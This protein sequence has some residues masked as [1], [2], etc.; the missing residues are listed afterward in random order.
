MAESARKLGPFDDRRGKERLDW[1]AFLARFFPNR[2]RHDFVALKAY[3]AYI[4]TLVGETPQQRSA[5]SRLLLDRRA[6][7]SRPAG[8]GDRV[9]VAALSTAVLTGKSEVGAPVR[10]QAG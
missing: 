6:G 5:S 1:A 10:R 9:P 3:E 7:H 8:V 2:R 4:H